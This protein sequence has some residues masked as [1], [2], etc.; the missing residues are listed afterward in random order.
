MPKFK[1][2]LALLVTLVLAG[3]AW[4]GD[5]SDCSQQQNS[6]AFFLGCYQSDHKRYPATLEQ[7]SKV[8]DRKA[9][10]ATLYVC[11]VSHKHYAYNVSSD[12]KSF[13]LKCQTK[14]HPSLSG[15]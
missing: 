4:S 3:N 14:G 10:V 13:Q 6:L 15:P 5:V 9:P 1:N 2:L 11:P 7:L 8:V 12:G